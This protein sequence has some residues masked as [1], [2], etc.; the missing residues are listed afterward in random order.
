[1]VKHIS[2]CTGCH[3]SRCGGLLPGYAESEKQQYADSPFQVRICIETG[4]LLTN[5]M[6]RENV[7]T[8]TKCRLIKMSFFLQ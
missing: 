3:N 5:I 7:G 8:H 2:S 1:M 4:E 6:S